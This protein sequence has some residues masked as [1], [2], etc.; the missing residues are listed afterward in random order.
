[1]QSSNQPSHKHGLAYRNIFLVVA[2]SLHYERHWQV[3]HPAWADGLMSMVI[4]VLFVAAI[5]VWIRTFLSCKFSIYLLLTF[6]SSKISPHFSLFSSSMMVR[7]TLDVVKWGMKLSCSLAELNIHPTK[8]IV[9]LRFNC[10]APIA[11]ISYRILL[12]IWH[13]IQEYA[14]QKNFG[15]RAKF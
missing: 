13:A 6:N 5:N 15:G 3:G 10:N 4:T 11:N 12:L 1:M 8:G 2:C 7:T 14:P 9:F